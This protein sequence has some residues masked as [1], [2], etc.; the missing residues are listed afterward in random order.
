MRKQ[1][2]VRPKKPRDITLRLEGLPKGARFKFKW[3]EE[4]H[5]GRTFFTGYARRDNA[6]FRKNII[7]NQKRGFMLKITHPA[8][9]EFKSGGE[10]TRNSVYLYYWMI[11]FARTLEK[12]TIPCPILQK[13]HVKHRSRFVNT[14]QMGWSNNRSMYEYWMNGYWTVKVDYQV[15]V[16][17]VEH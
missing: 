12:H 2:N 7:I 11:N 17:G 10:L 13:E 9:V 3:Y 1:K 8:C 14:N 6:Y 15:E 16:K 4:G 5:E